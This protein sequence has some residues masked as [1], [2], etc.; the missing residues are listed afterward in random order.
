MRVLF[1]TDN[2][3]PEVNAPAT[4]TYEHC[5]EWVRSGVEVTVITC[6]PNFPQGK[7]Y[8]GYKNRLV[9]K[10]RIEGIKVV[11]VW[12]YMSPNKGKI[13]RSLDY[14]SFSLSSFLA[15]LFIKTDLIVATSPQILAALSGRGLSF[16]K[17][18]PWVLEVRDL[19]PASVALV[20]E[21]SAG[22]LL[23]FLFWLEIKLYNSAKR[24]VVVTDSF[25]ENI[26]GKGI[27][28]KKI[29]VIKNGVNF[30]LYKNQPLDSELKSMLGLDGKFVF[31]YVGTHGLSHSLDFILNCVAQ[32]KEADS[33]FLFIGS[34]AKK[35]EL[36]L[37]AEQLALQNITFLEPVEK[38]EVWRYISLIDVML[39]PLRKDELF[40]TVIPSKIFE[41]AAMCTPIL[42]GVDGEAR[43]LI[44]D[45]NAGYYFE[46]ENEKSFLKALQKL[47]EDK[48]L[49]WE[50]QKGCLKLAKDFDR[51]EL[52]DQ[53][54]TY[55]KGCV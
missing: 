14:I 38:A 44:E 20:G 53:M 28:A 34:G 52:A 36:K 31:G 26:I 12:T 46:P 42:L 37:Q 35:Q 22:N 3:P 2:F 25:R 29:A 48:T 30:D 21:I 45:Y 50:L 15:G 19:W 43:K 27:E 13:K 23:R 6:A 39:V 47:K 49:Y 41:T 11:R 16:V 32:V 17:R 54:L 7:V 51:K 10:E 33:H 5:R 24:I 55:L 1:I 9:Y 4:R 40:K 18:K 8:K